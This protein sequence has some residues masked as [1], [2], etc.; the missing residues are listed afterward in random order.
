M[1]VIGR[2]GLLMA[3]LAAGDACTWRSTV[4]AGPASVLAN[5]PP[6]SAVIE[7]VDVEG[8][9]AQIDPATTLRFV[10][11][12]GATTEDFRASS[13][14]RNQVGILDCESG[15]L[16]TTWND[17]ANVQ[18]EGFDAALTT[19]I[20]SVVV[21]IVVA[22]IAGKGGGGGGNGAG[23][24]TGHA[25]GGHGGG[26]GG[27]GRV[28]VVHPGAAGGGH[29]V[30]V[31]NV[32]GP[33]VVPGEVAPTPPPP[34]SPSAPLFTPTAQRRS[35][36][37]LSTAI[38]GGTC[39]YGPT[40]CSTGAV[41]AGM[42]LANY[43]ELTGGV[44]AM[45]G[46]GLADGVARWAPFGGIG[47]H[48]EFPRFKQLAYYFGVEAGGSESLPFVFSLRPGLR[49]SPI[50]QLSIGLFPVSPT[51]IDGPSTR[52]SGWQFPTSI[53]VSTAF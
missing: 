45:W 11:W 31:S 39:V 46:W 4:G 13:L 28:A 3:L 37:A 24:G 49:F 36:I 47:L 32:G 8:R 6:S 33:V 34:P 43:V 30:L 10:R 12:D 51:Y 50:P 15:A 38:D 27:G 52:P 35:I 44:R 9:T 17:I 40:N 48:G 1:R 19:V 18:V 21:V 20:T 29:I 7:M 25:A 16:I 22:L 14:C 23:A 53:E 42:R 26:Y 5:A 2:A 41:R